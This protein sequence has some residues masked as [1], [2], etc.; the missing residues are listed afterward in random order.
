MTQQLFLIPFAALLFILPFPGTVAFRLLC[1][2][3]A[4]LLA[5]LRWRQLTPATL[6]IKLPLIAW[7][8]IAAASILYA[9]D[10]AYSLGEVKNELGYSIMAYVAFFAACRDE[11]RMKWMLLSLASGALVLCAWALAFVFINGY[12]N[13]GGGYGG[14]AAFATYL[15]TIF[16][17]MALLGFYF[18]DMRLRS[19]ALCVSVI[20]LI[21]GFFCQQRI[22]WPI[23]FLQLSI[24]MILY[25]GSLGLNRARIAVALLLAL[26]LAA[27]AL[28]GSQISRFEKNPFPSVTMENDTRI[29]F[30]P[31]VAE[32]IVEHPLIGA[33]FGRSTMS[34]AY[35]DLIPPENT[36]LWHPHNL[37]LNYGLAMGYPG[38]LVLLLVWGALLREYLRF[39]RSADAALRML[40]ACGIVLV[41]GVLARNLVNDMF[42]RDAAILFWAINGMLLGLGHRKTTLAATISNSR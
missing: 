36:E 19:F 18:K 30:W 38:I 14:T 25:G 17:A 41:I 29:R 10:P 15:V 12:W 6:P 27:T 7:A 31:K 21:A 39:W 20:L 26:L 16:P 3:A 1:L 28:L 42:M 11:H 35:P 23:I 32:R 37:V 40:G 24:G 5:I 2:S 34:K 33:G 8:I 13:Q 4:F 9:V 22:I